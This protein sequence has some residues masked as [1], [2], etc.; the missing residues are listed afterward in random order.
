MKSGQRIIFCFFCCI[1]IVFSISG[2]I[3]LINSNHLSPEGSYLLMP[4]ALT[5]A[6]LSALYLALYLRNSGLQHNN[7]KKHDLM[8]ELI[9]KA[10]DLILVM[11]TKGDI[12]FVN[13]SWIATLG[14]N[15]NEVSRMNIFDIV[16]DDCKG[17][18]KKH[19]QELLIGA[20]KGCF[21]VTYVTNSGKKITMEGNCC[22][23]FKNSKPYMIR[24]IFR[25]ISHRREQDE[26]I[27]RMAFYDMLT[28]LPNR[29]LLNDRLEQAIHQARR[30]HQQAALVYID[31][32]KFKTV[33]DTY[34]HTV[35]DTV[36][37]KCALRMKDCL[38]DNDT[39]AR[40]GGDEFLLILTGIKNQYD[41]PHIIEKIETVLSAPFVIDNLRLNISASMG[42]AIYP[43][44]TSTQSELQTKADEAMYVAKHQGGNRHCFY[45]EQIADNKILRIV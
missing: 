28:G 36:L 44:D 6:A 27:L 11:D 35:G 26:K 43:I 15:H 31:L 1:A 25:D 14:Y 9:I 21:E 33:N 3:Y 45:N 19:L 40:V 39:I 23:T 18:C 20:G 12:L 4:S 16:A 37:Q 30:Y 29:Y 10:K 42:T 5:A 17:D 7:D 13:D 24:G 22:C 34:G 32:D 38:R 8:S 41:I 2:F